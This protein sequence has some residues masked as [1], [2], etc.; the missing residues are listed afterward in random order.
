M[1]ARF[2]G[3]LKPGSSDCRQ[4]AIWRQEQERPAG[5][6]GSDRLHA[7]PKGNVDPGWENKRV[8]I[9]KRLC[10]ACVW[11][12]VKNVLTDGSGRW[13]TRIYAPRTGYWYWK[14]IVPKAD[15]YAKSVTRVYRTYV[16]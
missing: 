2:I 16:V 1:E 3:G 7:L 12:L 11:K 4:S 13:R 9:Y 8:Q 5:R 6:L 14:G 10:K 15:G